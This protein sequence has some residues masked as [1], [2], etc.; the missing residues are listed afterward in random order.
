MKGFG[1]VLGLMSTLVSGQEAADLGLEGGIP[2]SIRV[3]ETF[4]SRRFIVEF[5]TVRPFSILSA[6]LGLIFRLLLIIELQCS[7]CRQ[8]LGRQ[9]WPEG[10][11]SL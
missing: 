9:A 7:S 3:N 4:T 5:A 1:L 8:W 10:S 2:S 11:E 6:E